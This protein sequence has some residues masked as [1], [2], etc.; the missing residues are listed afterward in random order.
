MEDLFALFAGIFIAAIIFMIIAIA[1]AVV[2]LVFGI[3]NLTKRKKRMNE[4]AAAGTPYFTNGTVAD[5]RCSNRQNKK[6]TI[7]NYYEVALHFVGADQLNHRAF[8]GILTPMPL[9]LSVGMTLPLAVFI[10]PVLQPSA[11]AT[12]PYRGADGMLPPQIE[13]RTW[14]ERPIDETGTVMLQEHYYD[15]VQSAEKKNKTN[16]IIG[17][18]LIGIV[19]LRV[20]LYLISLGASVFENVMR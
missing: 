17:W 20:A 4:M 7:L 13:P 1:I 12:D 3:S 9:N 2:M 10:Q 11:S 15:A 16:L 6:G 19:I 14:L 18:V 8:I 5:L